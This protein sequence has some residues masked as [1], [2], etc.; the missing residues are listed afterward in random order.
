MEKKQKQQP[1]LRS[2]KVTWY[3]LWPVIQKELK[4]RF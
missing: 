3:R 2:V 4:V 1:K